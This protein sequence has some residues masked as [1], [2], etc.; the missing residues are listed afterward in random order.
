MKKT[1]EELQLNE[2]KVT[3]AMFLED[4]NKNIP[5][6][7][8]RVSTTVLRKFQEAHPGLFRQKDVWSVDK[9]RKRVMDWLSSNSD[10]S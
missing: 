4:Y 6:G 10:I 2:T 7:F 1:K 8:R 3:L 9:H 5:P